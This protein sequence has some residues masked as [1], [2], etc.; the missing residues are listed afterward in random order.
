MWDFILQN[1]FF[2]IMVG[3]LYAIVS[4]GMTMVYGLLNIL[5]VAHV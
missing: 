3:S 5:H 2:G 4:M 1:L